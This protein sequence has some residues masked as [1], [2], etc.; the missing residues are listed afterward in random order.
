MR[1][2]KRQNLQVSFGFYDVTFGIEICR[3]NSPKRLKINKELS[4]QVLSGGQSYARGLQKFKKMI[5]IKFDG[6]H[7]QGA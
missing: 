2:R 7:N 5:I 1:S 4:L 3:L 6:N